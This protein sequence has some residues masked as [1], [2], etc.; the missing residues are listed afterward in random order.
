MN[1]VTVYNLNPQ[2]TKER[3]REQIRNLVDRFTIMNNI[4]LPAEAVFAAY[5]EQP[6]GLMIRLTTTT[7]LIARFI[8]KK[9]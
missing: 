9:R 5:E 2:T 3:T 1:K 7:K 4:T 6:G 8:I